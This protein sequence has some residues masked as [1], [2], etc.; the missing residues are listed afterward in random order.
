[1]EPGRSEPSGSGEGDTGSRPDVVSSPGAPAADG[2]CFA[3]PTAL[4]LNGSRFRVEVAWQVPAQGSSG[5]G[6]AVPLTSDTGHFW[7]FSA[8]NVELVVKVVDGRGFNGHYWVFSGALSDVAYTI[9]V[10]D[11]GTGAVRTYSNPSGRLTSL[12]D[13]SAF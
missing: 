9:T 12:A 5:A 7:F 3:T 10:T 6:I 13:V 8:N 11:T 4:C 2:L 1:M